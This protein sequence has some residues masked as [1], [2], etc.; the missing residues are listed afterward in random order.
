MITPSDI[1]AVLPA[2]QPRGIMASERAVVWGTE[3]EATYTPS[4]PITDIRQQVEAQTSGRLTTIHAWQDVP[5]SEAYVSPQDGKRKRCYCGKWAYRYRLCPLHY[6]QAFA[7]INIGEP[8]G[9]PP[10]NS[11]LI[12]YRQYLQI[13]RVPRPDH[14]VNDESNHTT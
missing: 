12:H 9:N 14:G 2:P 3:M 4:D 1:L 7:D 6:Y 13:A 5:A 8:L 11:G 10:V